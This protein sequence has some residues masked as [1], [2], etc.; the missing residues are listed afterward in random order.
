MG[1]MA[2]SGF[3]VCL[4]LWKK[5]GKE[6]SDEVPLKNPFNIMPAVKFGLLYAFIV[7]LT[8]IV[9]DLAGDSGLYIVSALSG[10]TDVD[11]ITLTM[12]QISK[13]DPSKTSQATIAITLAAF[14]NTIM[15]TA[16]AVALGSKGAP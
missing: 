9:G 10:L 3:S 2:L 16:M 12:S 6:K 5:S 15:K 8:K 14:S 13:A 11:A 7:F 1:M 4:V